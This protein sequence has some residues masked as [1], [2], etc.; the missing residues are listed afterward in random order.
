M[1]PAPHDLSA[2]PQIGVD[3]GMYA[4]YASVQIMGVFQSIAPHL[5]KIFMLFIGVQIV[6]EMFNRFTSR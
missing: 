6:R 1:Y 4:E 5:M 2:F 3:F